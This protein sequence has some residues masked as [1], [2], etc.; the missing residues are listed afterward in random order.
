MPYRWGLPSALRMA[1]SPRPQTRMRR[2]PRSSR[3]RHCHS[4]TC[5]P[6]TAPSQVAARPVRAAAQAGAQVGARACG[7]CT[8]RTTERTR[9]APPPLRGGGRARRRL[10]F[11]YDEK[12][13]CKVGRRRRTWVRCGARR[14][15][16]QEQTL[17]WQHLRRETRSARHARRRRAPRVLRAVSAASASLLASPARRAALRSLAASASLASL[18]ISQFPRRESA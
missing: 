2:Q 5:C 14:S 11:C 3:M 15:A 12:S 17:E 10:P 1:C 9:M 7:R 4:C 6:S 18:T 16:A 13:E 8:M